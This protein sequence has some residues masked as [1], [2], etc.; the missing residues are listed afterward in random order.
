MLSDLSEPPQQLPHLRADQESTCMQ[1][2]DFLLVIVSLFLH[3]DN[4][5]LSAKIRSLLHRPWEGVRQRLWFAVNC[6]M[7]E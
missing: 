5:K 3:S 6:Q 1:S 2:Q 4:A 7:D